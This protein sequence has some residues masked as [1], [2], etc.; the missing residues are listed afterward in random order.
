VDRLS[1]ARLLLAQ[2]HPD[3]ALGVL[4]ELRA[5]TAQAAQTD[6]LIEILALHAMTLWAT[7]RKERAVET[8]TQALALAE[9]EG[10][11]RTFVDEGAAMG[12]LL[13]ATLEVRERGR[14]DDTATISARYLAKLLAAC[15]DAKAPANADGQLPE[16]LS[17]RETAVLG[18][19]AAGESNGEIAARLVVST[20]T[21][22][23]HLNNLYRKLG[24]SSRTRAVARA[25]ELGLI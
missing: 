16:P 8:L 23:T 6:D 25:R 22:K 4:D 12:E 20:T 13:A 2:G 1:S 7:K 14:R 10:Y 15:A 11:I 19:M 24:T 5:A 18:L 17:E 3:E 21:V 9:P